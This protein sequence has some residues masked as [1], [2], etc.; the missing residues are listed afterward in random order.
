MHPFRSLGLLVLALLT[1]LTGVGCASTPKA[2]DGQVA[3]KMRAMQTRAFETTD[4][5]KTVRTAMATLQDLGFVID[6]ADSELGSVS[7]T[8][9]DRYAIKMTVTVRKRGETQLL[10]RANAQYN[11]QPVEDATFYQ[12]FFAAFSKSMFLDAQEIDP[13]APGF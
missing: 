7:A 13:A 10:V 6:N 12:Q 5:N 4:V 9:L 11:V 3:L 2:T 1:C 8:K